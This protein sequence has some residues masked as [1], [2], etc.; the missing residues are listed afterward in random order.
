MQGKPRS[1][2]P[3]AVSAMVRKTEDGKTLRTFMIRFSLSVRKAASR[4]GEG[5]EGSNI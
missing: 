2:A 5:V 1:H 3:D 4:M